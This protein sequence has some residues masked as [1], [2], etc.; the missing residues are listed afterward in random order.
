M[1]VMG[2]RRERSFGGAKAQSQTAVCYGMGNDGDRKIP[3]VD[4]P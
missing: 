1:D 2:K 3:S 4:N